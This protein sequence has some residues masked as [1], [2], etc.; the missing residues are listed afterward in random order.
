M[1]YKQFPENF[2]VVRFRGVF[3]VSPNNRPSFR[4]RISKGSF[5][6][7][8]QHCS[9]SSEL[10]RAVFFVVLKF[11]INHPAKDPGE[12]ILL[13]D[14]EEELLLKDPEDELIL[15]DPEEEL[16]SKDS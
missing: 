3:K 12:E 11:E 8:S 5:L 6:T 16:L 9:S 7:W 10:K 13:K 4:C 14:P 1:V 15:K 2:R